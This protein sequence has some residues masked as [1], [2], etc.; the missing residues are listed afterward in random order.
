[1]VA[2][3]AS[4]V[5]LNAAKRPPLLAGADEVIA[6]LFASEHESDSGPLLLIQNVHC[7]VV[8]LSETGPLVLGTRFSHLDP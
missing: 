7:E 1:M 3:G 2:F 8:S 4:A 6:M 5:D